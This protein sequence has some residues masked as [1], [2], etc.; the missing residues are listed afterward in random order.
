[1][2]CD[3]FTTPTRLLATSPHITGSTRDGSSNGG[4]DYKAFT[5]DTDL[6]HL[7]LQQKKYPDI[8]YTLW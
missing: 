7:L 8:V 6:E 3:L 4:C 5:A 1:M 2:W